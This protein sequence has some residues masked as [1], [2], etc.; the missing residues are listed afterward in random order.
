M[1][2]KKASLINA[3]GKFSTIF[4]NLAVTAVLARILTPNDYGVVAVITVFS[5]FFSTFSDMGFGAAIIQKK[6]L[7]VQDVNNIFSFTG[8]IAAILAFL[9]LLLSYPISLFYNND[10]YLTLGA[11]LSVS[12]FF[13]ALNMV[14]N[15]M[16]NRDKKFV[17]IAVRTVVVYLSAAL[18]T[19]ALAFAG[20]RYYALAIQ[21]ILTALFNFLWNYLQTRPRFRLRF[22]MDSIKKVINYSGFQFAFNIVNYFSRNLDNLLTGKF[23]GSAAL[24]YYNKAY[25][26]MLY[27][28]NNLAGIVSPVLHP[29]LS[30]YQNQPQTIYNKYMR[31]VKFLAN[32][33][34]FVAPVCYLAGSEAITILYGS[35]WL[36]SVACFQLL[37]F[38]IIPQMI[39]SSVGAVFQAI[40]Q[41]KLLFLSSCINTL[42]TVAAILV[43][44]FAG[45][46]IVTLSAYIALAYNI[47]F[48]TSIIVLICSGFHFN[49]FA[50]VRNL[51]P[52]L[53]ML[54][55]MIIGV[56]LYPFTI[57]GVVFSGLVKGLWLS[58]FYLAA[59]FVTKEHRTL[60]SIIKRK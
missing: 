52:Q 16:M 15:G 11:M 59:L 5:T 18:I 40:N 6:E 1:N 38:A 47:H 41:T 7:S 45:G 20:L 2:I 29:I 28:V 53:C 50:F 43:G 25:N 8:Y 31:L 32:L 35:N 30:D 24:G 51:L 22:Q 13:N 3:I 26:L 48:L 42:I 37:S 56:V 21:A 44:I 14:P 54:V 55:I 12:L 39:N 9:F 58:V 10:A 36:D 57:H 19:I 33:G 49:F 17:L 46:N 4:L 34:I 23:I 27:P 60:L